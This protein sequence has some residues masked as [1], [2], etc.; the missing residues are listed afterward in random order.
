MHVQNVQK[1]VRGGRAWWTARSTCGCQPPLA[2]M[3]L[4]V[5]ATPSGAMITLAS[6]SSPIRCP[7]AGSSG[8]AVLPPCQILCKGMRPMQ[9]ALL[10]ESGSQEPAAQPHLHHLARPSQLTLSA[11]Q[12]PIVTGPSID[13]APA[14]QIP[15]LRP[16]RGKCP[17]EPNGEASTPRRQAIPAVTVDC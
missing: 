6:T 12:L 1:G 17:W 7:V 2:P 3:L 14:W 11:A 15:C 5:A 10:R 13:V 8:M 9:E 4:G 16:M